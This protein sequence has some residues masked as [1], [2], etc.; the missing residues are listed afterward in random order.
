VC[1]AV[2]TIEA[3][4]FDY[5]SVAS[6][7]QFAW[8]YFFLL[9]NSAPMLTALS[10]TLLTRASGLG[11]RLAVYGFALGTGS[12]TLYYHLLWAFDVGGVTT[13]SSTSSLIFV[14]IPVY[15]TVFGLILAAP[16]GL[17]GYIATAR[18][19]SRSSAQRVRSSA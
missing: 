2:L 16:A 8:L 14:W 7:T 9:W 6:A 19:A 13:R 15:A 18:R 17:I 5:A 12:V 10:L 1:L 4:A 11:F 3:L